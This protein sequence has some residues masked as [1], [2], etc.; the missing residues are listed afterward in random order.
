MK[1]GDVVANFWKRVNKFGPLPE[2]SPGLGPCWL[3]QG[4][5]Q[6]KG[7]GRV[8]ISGKMLMVHRYSYELANGPIPDGLT[9]DHLCR[10]RLCVRPSH[11]EP[12]TNAVNIARGEGLSTVNTA[13]T[14]CPKG[15]PFDAVTRHGRERYC[16]RC[17]QAY[18][19]VRYH[20][21]P[22]ETT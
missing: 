22:K 15:H 17:R 1:I 10:T 4:A 13:K 14:H 8:R 7:Y 9:L 18:D 16:R 11:L 20:G 2:N 21:V 5:P 6:K 12:V 3:W 19:Y